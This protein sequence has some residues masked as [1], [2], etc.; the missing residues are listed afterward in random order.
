[1]GSYVLCNGGW[2][3]AKEGEDF[4][5]GFSRVDED[6][7]GVGGGGFGQ[8]DV[9]LRVAADHVEGDVKLKFLY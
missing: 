5:E 4:G 6:D 7:F 1:M 8:A 2:L 9:L 3:T